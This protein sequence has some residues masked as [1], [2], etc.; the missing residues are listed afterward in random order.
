MHTKGVV[1]TNVQKDETSKMK[2]KNYF[3][4]EGF[5]VVEVWILKIHMVFLIAFHVTIQSKGPVASWRPIEP[6]VK[7]YVAKR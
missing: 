2:S 3:W 5:N 6:V 1:V 4:S 7:L